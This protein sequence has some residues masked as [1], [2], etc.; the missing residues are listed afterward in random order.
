MAFTK[1]GCPVS[2]QRPHAIEQPSAA[3]KFDDVTLP[4]AET[5]HFD[6]CKAL[7]RPCEAG[8]GV[9]SAGEQHQ[10]GLGLKLIAHGVPLAPREAA[11]NGC[12]WRGI[13]LLFHGISNKIL[14]P[15]R[16]TPSRRLMKSP[17]PSRAAILAISAMNSAIFCCRWCFTPVWR[18]SRMHL[19][20]A[21]WSRPS[22]AR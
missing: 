15:S 10:R 6:A 3:I 7:Q 11:A 20:S 21:M 2:I 22:P 9:L 13:D 18:K 12:E 1:P 14:R 17:M 16:P 5:Q 4:V 8:G 19:R